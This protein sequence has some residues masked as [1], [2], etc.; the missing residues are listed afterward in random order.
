MLVNLQAG[1]DGIGLSC[2][3]YDSYVRCQISLQQPH[4]ADFIESCL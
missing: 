3:G 4:I 1:V 2:D